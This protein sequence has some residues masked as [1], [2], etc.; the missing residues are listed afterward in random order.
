MDSSLGNE[1][2]SDRVSCMTDSYMLSLVDCAMAWARESLN[3]CERDLN[4]NM[5]L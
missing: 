3:R 1:A 2:V 4:V 5:S